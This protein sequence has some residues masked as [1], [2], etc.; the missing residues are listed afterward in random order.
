MHA[1]GAQHAPHV[2]V[3]G[4]D[5]GLSPPKPPAQIYAKVQCCAPPSGHA[6]A[7][8]PGCGNVTQ[9]APGHSPGS[10]AQSQSRP[11]PQLLPG[12]AG[13]VEA[14]VNTS[15]LMSVRPSS[16]MYLIDMLLRRQRNTCHARVPLNVIV[17][18]L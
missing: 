15:V 8:H 18:V 4:Q 17:G 11:P 6:K 10:R 14:L 16:V 13:D 1:R 2:R 3:D 12:D 9:E 7:G 5:P